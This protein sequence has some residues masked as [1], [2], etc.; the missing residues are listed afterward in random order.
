MSRV[1]SSRIDRTEAQFYFS[2][3]EQNCTFPVIALAAHDTEADYEAATEAASFAELACQ[4]AVAKPLAGCKPG[5][6]G[7]ARK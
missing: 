7:M 5:C 1:A 4:S 2:M 3:S 6:T